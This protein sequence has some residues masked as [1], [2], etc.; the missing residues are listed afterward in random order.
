MTQRRTVPVEGKLTE[1]T[2][3][4][5]SLQEI[6]KH[7]QNLEIIVEEEDLVRPT[8]A[9][10]TQLFECILYVLAPWLEPIIDQEKDEMTRICQHTNTEQGVFNDLLLIFEHFQAFLIDIQY[11]DFDISDMVSPN[12]QR[13]LRILNVI[14]NYD[15][16]NESCWSFYEQI[17]VNVNNKSQILDQ[18]DDMVTAL[19]LN[20][21]QIEMQYRQEE[22]EVRKLQD[23]LSDI[24][25]ELQEFRIYNESLAS[26]HEKLRRIRQELKDTLQNTQFA[27]LQEMD[28]SNKY[29]RL[30]DFQVDRVQEQA[31]EAEKNLSQVKMDMIKKEQLLGV[32]TSRYALEKSILVFFGRVMDTISNYF[33][34]RNTYNRTTKTSHSV[35][36]ELNTIDSD[37]REVTLKVHYGEREMDQIEIKIKRIEEQQ[38]KKQESMDLLRE[39]DIKEERELEE[40]YKQKI[41]ETQSLN[42]EYQVVD[43]E[44][45]NKLKSYAIFD[46]TAKEHIS[47]LNVTIKI[48]IPMN[49]KSD[50]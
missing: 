18:L 35:T 34:C 2:I 30:K 4:N 36:K 17:A 19:T 33:V 14:V 22:P 29:K 15:K 31:R 11:T 26:D 27:I 43:I 20:K 38:K 41:A 28:L 16:F 21:Q 42:V 32:R 9:R 3:E 7:F 8:C 24:E 6:I 49:V 12:P 1:F 44:V 50:L 37:L 13:L 23:M 48:M 46:R 25:H 47:R 45:E 39:N 5:Y 10:T 40:Q